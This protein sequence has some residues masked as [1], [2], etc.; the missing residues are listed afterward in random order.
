MS[1]RVPREEVGAGE[2]RERGQGEAELEQ[3]APRQS[4]VLGHAVILPH[5]RERRLRATGR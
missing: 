4:L 2:R 5:E 3:P 1:E